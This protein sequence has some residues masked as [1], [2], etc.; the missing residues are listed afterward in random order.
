MLF[1][2]PALCLAAQI[3]QTPDPAL[4]DDYIAT[5]TDEWP[6]DDITEREIIAERSLLQPAGVR[7]A[8]ILWEKT[9]WRV[10][11]TREKMNLP[12]V[13][14]DAPLFTI[15]AD[16]AK[17]GELPVYVEEQGRLTR[18][19]APAAVY[20]KLVRRDT[21][22]V[23]NI[24]KDAEEVMVVEN[25]LN[26]ADVRRFRI[27]ETWYFDSRTSSLQVRILGIAPLLERYTDS[28]EYLGEEVL[29]WVHLPTARALLARHEVFTPG[30]NTAATLSWADWLDM[31]HFAGHIIKEQN[32][33]GRR[34]EDY[35]AGADLLLEADRIQQGIFN[36]EH[37]LWSW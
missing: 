25:E 12:F 19:I 17:T 30:G 16:A 32:V 15:L 29:F 1:C 27:K 6:L 22:Y 4:R 13:F 5:E 9:V 18:R 31:R 7:E 24:D 26:W 35:L 37:D 23:Y 14:P 36:R 21:V 11:D 3:P 28:E 8:D 20:A 33:H 34:L 10:I 2:L